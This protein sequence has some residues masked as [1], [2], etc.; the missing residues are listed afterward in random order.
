MFLIDIVINFLILLSLVV[1]IVFI[2]SLNVLLDIFID[3]MIVMNFFYD[4]VFMCLICFWV[5]LRMLT[6]FNLYLIDSLLRLGQIL[7]QTFS[8]VREIIVFLLQTFVRI[9]EV[10]VCL[11]EAVNFCL[12]LACMVFL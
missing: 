6:I 9:Q 8:G 2:V 12:E 4:L 3:D 7:L 11:S 10:L 1:M 5:M